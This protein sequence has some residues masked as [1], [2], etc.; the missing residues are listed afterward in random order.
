MPALAYTLY[1]SSAKMRTQGRNSC[2]PLNVPIDS[3][4]ARFGMEKPVAS[5]AFR[6]AEYISTPKHAT[7]PVECMSTPCVGSAPGRRLNENCDTFMPTYGIGSS[8]I[9]ST[10]CPMATLVASPIMSTFQVFDEK[11]N[12]RDTRRLH[13]ITFRVS[14]FA[15]N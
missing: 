1:P 12:E 8:S 10:G 15:M 14:S 13:S 6:Y 9:G 2:F 4:T 3:S 7:S 11:G 5:I